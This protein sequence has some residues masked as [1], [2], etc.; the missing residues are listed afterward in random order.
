MK[1]CARAAKIWRAV[2]R[3]RFGGGSDL[4]AQQ[5]RVQRLGEG[6]V[7]SLSSGADKSRQKAG[8]TRRTPKS[9]AA[10][11]SRQVYG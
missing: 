3:H 9:V 4:S 5:S 6:V 11:V 8:R 1:L 7:P 10:A 2:T